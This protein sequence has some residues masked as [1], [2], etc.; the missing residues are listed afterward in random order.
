MRAAVLFVTALALTIALAAY[1]S[2]PMQP[3]QAQLWSIVRLHN[4]EGRFFCS[5]FIVSDT[6]IVT[7]AHCISGEPVMVKNQKHKLLGIAMPAKVN[8]R[9]DQGVL[10]MLVGSL[11][12]RNK[13]P[14]EQNGAAIE[15]SFNK[16]QSLVACGYPYGGEL[17]CSRVEYTGHFQFF[18]EALGF[19]YPGMS[20]GPVIDLETGK[21]V[22][23]NTAVTETH[24]ILSPTVEILN[25]R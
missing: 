19:L 1:N 6:K 12:E 16:S 25:E 8:E 5:G 22:G 13:L 20:G 10:K 14:L 23:L 18:M 9:G 7:A 15:R 11:K 4:L 21:A 17:T 2:Q 24:L 3:T